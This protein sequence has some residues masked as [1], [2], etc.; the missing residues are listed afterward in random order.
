MGNISDEIKIIDAEIEKTEKAIWKEV[1][2]YKE[3]KREA[4]DHFKRYNDIPP[5]AEIFKEARK[6]LV[7][8]MR[9]G[10]K[11][12][13]AHEHTIKDLQ[14]RLNTLKQS[15]ENK[16][17]K[18]VFREDLEEVDKLQKEAEELKQRKAEL[19]A[20]YAKLGKSG[21]WSVSNDK[22][23]VCLNGKVITKLPGIPYKLFRCLLKNK[24]KFVKN[25]I[26]EKCWDNKPGYAHFLGDTINELETKLKDGLKTFKG[27]NV[28]EKIIE[29]KKNNKRKIIAYKLP[30]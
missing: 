16:L 23:E 5:K 9:N 27:I 8:A 6:V 29:S 12:L 26:L 17:N 7:D 30:T 21:S 19:S 13:E 14:S 1:E 18:I 15:R 24:G 25:E 10:G 20:K 22:Q 3:L 4:S 2:N 11:D 28:Q